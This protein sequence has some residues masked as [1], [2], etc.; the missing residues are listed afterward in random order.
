MNSSKNI[1]IGITHGDPNGIGY[2]VILKTLNN[3]LILDMCS[4]IVYGAKTALDFHKKELE[5]EKVKFQFINK[6]EEAKVKTASFIDCGS[7]DFKVE[8][9][10]GTPESGKLAFDALEKAIDDLK[11]GNIDVLV[12]A[13]INKDNIQSDNF[14]FPGHTEYLASK[15]D[16][17]KNLMFMVSSKLKVAVA[18]GHIPLNE[19][20]T[21]LTTDVIVEKI[22]LMEKSLKDDFSI[23]KPKIAVLGLNPHAGDNGLLG[24]EDQEIILPAI[25]KAKEKGI[26]AF[27]PFAAD[28]FFGSSSYKSYDGVT[29]MYHDQG[30]IPFK[31]LAFGQGTNFT[32]GLSFIRTSPDHGTGF[33][34]AGQNKAD[35]SSLRQALYFAIDIYRNRAM[36]EELKSNPLPKSKIK[37]VQDKNWSKNKRS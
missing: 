1:K 18:T 26:L 20:S 29:A 8:L 23:R 6:A 16:K 28:G 34:I 12:T 10:K 35:E 33:D 21:Q 5:L 15:D 7:N 14:N 4:P 2:E 17:E 3:K 27:G 37:K 31:A 25:A 36:N 11:A 30:L 9:G 32:A 24:K 19:I 13:P 22:E